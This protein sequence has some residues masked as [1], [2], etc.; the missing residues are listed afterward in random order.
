M[1]AEH[2]W[3]MLMTSVIAAGMRN[4]CANIFLENKIEMNSEALCWLH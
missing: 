2:I 4:I 3:I 1:N